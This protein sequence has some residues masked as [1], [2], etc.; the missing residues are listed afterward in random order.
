M[1]PILSRRGGGDGSTTTDTPP[2]SVADALPA[3]AD[4][5]K[6]EIYAV[7]EDDDEGLTSAPNVKRETDAGLFRMRSDYLGSGRD[8]FARHSY[9]ARSVHGQPSHFG[10][11]LVPEPVGII[12]IVLERISFDENRLFIEVATTGDGALHDITAT[13]KLR[14]RSVGALA[15]SSAVTLDNI[16]TPRSN[17]RRFTSGILT[18]EP[19]SAVGH[20]G[21]TRSALYDIQILD[22]ADAVVEMHSGSHLDP[23]MDQLLV[24]EELA[25][26]QQRMLI[27][28]AEGRGIVDVTGLGAPAVNEEN[29]KNFFVDFD[30]PRVWMGRRTPTAATPAEG[31]SDAFANTN[32]RGEYSRNPTS[33]PAN[34]RYYN[35]SDHH[36]HRVYNSA[37]STVNFSDAW[38]STYHWLGERASEAEAVS[39][40]QNFNVAHHYL[41]FLSGSRDVREVDNDTYVVAVTAGYAYGVQPISGPHGIVSRPEILLEEIDDADTHIIDVNKIN[42]LED[43]DS[44]PT[45]QNVFE[46]SRALEIGDDGKLLIVEMVYDIVIA[47]ST[48]VAAGFGDHRFDVVWPARA[49]RLLPEHDGT[50]GSTSGTLQGYSQR[51]RTVTVTGFAEAMWHFARGR[52]SSGADLLRLSIG[53]EATHDLINLKARIYLV[54]S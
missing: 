7:S 53:A 8:G 28:I 15:W 23:L 40:I 43:D 21:T 30:V 4:A 14:H 50:G 18:D 46:L 26:L 25:D 10:G 24:N 33:T 48:T 27:G 47:G 36:W 11:S 45:H 38:G 34:Q 13:I 51:P 16:T 52:T 1:S 19:L 5:E 32:Y 12:G 35:F 41:W 17:V 44:T 9:A 39:H 2:I 31:T 54:G 6:D 37:W 22:N 29:Y 49:V 42:W 20:A 3:V